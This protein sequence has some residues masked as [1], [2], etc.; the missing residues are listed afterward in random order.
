MWMLWYTHTFRPSFQWLPVIALCEKSLSYFICWDS[1][2]GVAYLEAS[3]VAVIGDDNE[4]WWVNAGSNERVHVVM[5]EV[6]HLYKND[7]HHDKFNIIHFE[8]PKT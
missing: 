6:P 2:Y 4:V 1:E 3:F 5:P 8:A 7:Q